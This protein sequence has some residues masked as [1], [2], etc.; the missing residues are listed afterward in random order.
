MRKFCLDPVAVYTARDVILI[1]LY[2]L[3]SPG[4]GICRA[5]WEGGG[6]QSASIKPNI[7]IFPQENRNLDQW[8]AAGKEKMALF[9]HTQHCTG[10]L[11]SWSYLTLY[12]VL[13]DFVIVVFSLT[14]FCFVC[15]CSAQILVWNKELLCQYCLHVLS[16]WYYL[17]ETLA[18]SSRCSMPIFC[19]SWRH[20]HGLC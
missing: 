5:G 3:W 12:G 7:S 17:T 15:E 10:P 1:D 2:K 4:A 16:Q 14:L 18:G 8:C 20:V 6:A 19:N 9:P 11:P 13:P